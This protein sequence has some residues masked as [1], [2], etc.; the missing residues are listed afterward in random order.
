M[1]D[2]RLR[3]ATIAFT[4]LLLGAPIA[5]TAQGQCSVPSNLAAWWPLDGTTADIA[6]GQH[7][8]LVGG[9]TFASS[10]TGQAL[11][12][13]G[14]S[15]YMSVADS[16]GLDPTA[17]ITVEAWIKPTV[18]Q[19]YA[20]VAKKTGP[21][22]MAGYVLELGGNGSDV[23]F[24][25]FVDGYGW[26]GIGGGRAPIGQWTHVAGTYDGHAA[27]LYVNGVL[28]AEGSAAG[29]LLP[30][31]GPLHIGH[32]P[33]GPWLFAGLIDEVGVFGAGLPADEV[34]AIYAA[35]KCRMFDPFA[36]PL[37]LP[38][39]DMTVPTASPS[40]RSVAF[41]SALAWDAVDGALPAACSPVSGATFMLGTTAVSCTATNSRGISGSGIFRVTVVEG[42]QSDGTDFLVADLENHRVIGYDLRTLR[43]EGEII[44]G[45]AGGLGAPDGMALSGAYLFVTGYYEHLIFRYDATTGEPAPSAGHTGAVFATNVGNRGP[46]SGADYLRVGP[47]HNLY[48]STNN[49]SVI[50][51]YDGLTGE[52]RP[53]AD[54]PGTSIFAVTLQSAGLD[55]G[56]DGNLYVASFYPSSV[57]RMDG[58]TGRFIDEFIPMSPLTGSRL[59]DLV[60]GPDGN[61]YVSG[62]T[63]DPF[64][65]GVLRRFDSAGQPLPAPGRSGSVVAEFEQ[66]ANHVGFGP[67]GR[68][69]QSTWTYQ[70][71]WDLLQ[72]DPQRGVVLTHILTPHGATPYGIVFRPS[73]PTRE[74]SPLM[75][76]HDLTV[77]YGM[78][79]VTLEAVLG[80]GVYSSGQTIDFTLRGLSAGSAPTDGNGLAMLHDVS[81]ASLEPGVYP[82]VATFAGTADVSA[83]HASAELT[84]LKQTPIVTV[85][86]VITVTVYPGETAV[87]PSS[88]VSA[89]GV[90]GSFDYI[91]PDGLTPGTRNQL[92]LRF[93]PTDAVHYAVVDWS[94]HTAFINL[95]TA[96]SHP[97][98]EMRLAVG[99][100]SDNAGVT[101]DAARNVLYIGNDADGTIAV[102]D[103][104]S[105]QT[106]R[107]IR[108]EY[109]G[110]SGWARYTAIDPSRHRLYVLDASQPILW[111]IDTTADVVVGASVIEDENLWTGI[112]G[113]PSASIGFVVNPTTGLAYLGTR[114]YPGATLFAID[115]Q[116]PAHSVAQITTPDCYQASVAVD[117]GTNLV[118]DGCGNVVGGDPADPASFNKV[119]FN[120]GA[121][122]PVAV[123]SRTHRAYLASGYYQRDPLRLW[124]FDG[125]PK[126]PTYGQMASSISLKESVPALGVYLYAVDMSIDVNPLTDL[127]YLKIT[128]L[129][130][131]PGG[132]AAIDGASLA[133]VSYTH[134]AGSAAGRRTGR[135]AVNPMTGRVYASGGEE[136]TVT[137]VFQDRSV[138][139]APTPPSAGPAVI[140]VPSGTITFATI[141]AAGTTTVQQV[142]VSQLGLPP[143]GRFS[144]SGA[145]AYEVSTTATVGAPIQLCFNVSSIEE[146]PTFDSLAVL[147]GENGAL[148]DRTT[149]RDFAS[150]TICATV[151][152]L[153]PFV[154][155]RA[156]TMNYTVKTLYSTKSVKS[157]STVPLKIQLLDSAGVNASDLAVTVTAAQMTLKGT[158]GTIPIA[159]AGASNPGST[160]RF[161][162]Q[163]AGYIFTLSTRGLR[164][165]V[166]QLS[167]RATGDP[168]AHVIEFSVDR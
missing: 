71:S 76:A 44:P 164:P 106:V 6:G 113:D 104:A 156:K 33:L 163:L 122:G 40:G 68:V 37:V 87:D 103:G 168:A 91:W 109:A 57:W 42:P 52:P 162:P 80:G 136:H 137:E 108:L 36:P 23:T 75:E 65:G 77:T 55:F 120:L 84:V 20:T 79:T 119:L 61:L 107:T 140:S 83:S 2:I 66:I 63:D 24:Y 25:V 26:L 97:T 41:P 70:G 45:G 160:F 69:Y 72:I 159:D 105:H 149:S 167:L 100:T 90:A 155:A 85:P 39:A 17:G 154:I 46:Y 143:P 59:S 67:D 99:G 3:A 134:L 133:T 153:S 8:T 48:V 157:G 142:D 49:G 7:G 81:L 88:F 129:Q 138:S 28:T 43:Y 166:Y 14:T 93:T 165:G 9:A 16:P 132:F 151:S 12:L 53:S 56:P 117:A 146:Q 94:C 74:S 31:Q 152:S 21:I 27:R 82:I 32:D 161:D 147:H 86:D 158:S 121:I 50:E 13:D 34:R 64:S 135:I 150:R 130:S 22:A 47:D 60:W 54:H 102:I 118:Y 131:S 114:Q 92:C 145:L 4:G 73:N 1:A 116:H 89:N 18:A 123:N 19:P 111:T 15:G 139:S 125:N 141:A 35:G 127:V 95:A 11:S 144:L 78:A 38:Q 62:R 30:A 51:R 10:L 29:T 58:V 101:I 98:L 110:L 126:S 124:A 128:D 112:G 5:A 148:V 115:V 96:R